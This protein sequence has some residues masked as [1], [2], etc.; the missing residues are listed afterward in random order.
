MVE[1]KLGLGDIFFVQIYIS[2]IIILLFS[3][4]EVRSYCKNKRLIVSNV[5]L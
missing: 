2:Y 4:D 5:V 3:M 1:S